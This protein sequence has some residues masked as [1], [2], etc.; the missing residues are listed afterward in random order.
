MR[1]LNCLVPLAVL[2]S[3]GA[4]GQAVSDV[5]EAHVFIVTRPRTQ[6][7]DRIHVRSF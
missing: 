3:A 6:K 7:I 2:V 1:L 4:W 5:A